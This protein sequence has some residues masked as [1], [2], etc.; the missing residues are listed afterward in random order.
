[1]AARATCWRWTGLYC[2]QFPGDHDRSPVSQAS[3]ETTFHVA[4]SR[5]R[6]VRKHNT[7]FFPSGKSL[8]IFQMAN[9]AGCHLAQPTGLYLTMTWRA[10]SF[11]ILAA[12]AAQLTIYPAFTCY[13]DGD[14]V[15]S[16]GSHENYH[17]PPLFE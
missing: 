12:S 1:M 5:V 3:G 8:K 17:G 11:T 2:V 4:Y 9:S 14:A 7:L 10:S 16:L 13:F 6:R 15:I